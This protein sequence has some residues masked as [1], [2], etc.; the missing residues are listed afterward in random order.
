[1]HQSNIP[2]NKITKTNQNIKDQN[3]RGNIPDKIWHEIRTDTNGQQTFQTSQGAAQNL[4]HPPMSL[5]NGHD[6]FNPFPQFQY[7]P[8]NSEGQMH[9]VNKMIFQSKNFLTS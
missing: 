6:H 5:N 8:F 2:I 7:F 9:Q 4:V 1:M 3:E